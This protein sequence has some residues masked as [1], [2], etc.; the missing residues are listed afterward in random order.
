MR[1][2]NTDLQTHHLKPHKHQKLNTFAIIEDS[3]TIQ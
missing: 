3:L 1:S 2:E